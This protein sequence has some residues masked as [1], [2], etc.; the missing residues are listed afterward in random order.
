MRFPF[1]K[2]LLQLI[3]GKLIHHLTSDLFLLK[4]LDSLFISPLVP[5]TIVPPG[6][7][8]FSPKTT[9]SA[10]VRACFRRPRGIL[11][12]R[13]VSTGSFCACAPPDVHFYFIPHLR[14]VVRRS[15][16][17]GASSAVYRH[18]PSKR[19]AASTIELTASC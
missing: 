2:F 11:P 7:L 13:L 12:P 1:R 5:Q 9:V 10:T 16:S 8:N 15:P 3:S 18:R 14:V 4:A 6:C 17:T 19:T